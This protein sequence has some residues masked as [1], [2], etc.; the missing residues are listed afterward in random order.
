MSIS[1][2]SIIITFLGATVKMI[3]KSKKFH[4]TENKSGNIQKLH[5]LKIFI[6]L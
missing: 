4:K 1:K 5:W 2:S 3:V 6:K